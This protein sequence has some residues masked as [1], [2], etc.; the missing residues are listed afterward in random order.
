MFLSEWFMS[1][2]SS[3]K[4]FT[5]VDECFCPIFVYHSNPSVAMIVY[6]S[7]VCCCLEDLLYVVMVNK[8]LHRQ[9]YQCICAIRSWSATGSIILVPSFPRESLKGEY[10]AITRLLYLAEEII[11][12]SHSSISCVLISKTPCSTLMRRYVQIIIHGQLREALLTQ[13]TMGQSLHHD[14]KQITTIM[15]MELKHFIKSLLYCSNSKSLLSY[16]VNIDLAS[17][18]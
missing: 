18:V 12:F 14:Q 16:W 17:D 13:C 2:S 7:N 6:S 3:Q 11:Q 10:H 15:E 4:H 1:N 9:F 8:V 5:H